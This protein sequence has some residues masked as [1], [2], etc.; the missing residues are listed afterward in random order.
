MNFDET[1]QGSNY[2][3]YKCG[4]FGGLF[5]PFSGFWKVSKGNTIRNSHVSAEFSAA[6]EIL[7]NI[8]TASERGDRGNVTLYFFHWPFKTLK[9]EGTNLRNVSFLIIPLFLNLGL[10]HQNPLNSLISPS[11][12]TTLIVYKQLIRNNR[13]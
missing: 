2:N 8:V 9:K 6:N 4:R 13:L 3:N 12:K 1:D 11:P 10:S 7:Y 5:P